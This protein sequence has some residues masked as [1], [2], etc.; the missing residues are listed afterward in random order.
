[1]RE[2]GGEDNVVSGIQRLVLE[3]T[4]CNIIRAFVLELS[5]ERIPETPVAHLG[6]GVD[7]ENTNCW[8]L[9]GD[10]C[11]TPRKPE[12]IITL[13]FTLIMLVRIKPEILAKNLPRHQEYNQCGT[14]EKLAHVARKSHAVDSQ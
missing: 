7:T 14:G 3:S 11:R 5:A 2:T 10:S 4:P 9:W 8:I 13:S 6:E 1:M 12:K